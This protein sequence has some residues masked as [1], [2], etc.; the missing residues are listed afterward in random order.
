MKTIDV[1]DLPEPLAR[2]V[3]SM[4]QALREQLYG[5]EQAQQRVHLPVWK[6][7]VKSSLRRKDFCDEIEVL[8]PECPAPDV[9]DTS[10]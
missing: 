2:A 7:T 3:E 9:D 1:S 5:K 6:G 8:K 10:L 4:V